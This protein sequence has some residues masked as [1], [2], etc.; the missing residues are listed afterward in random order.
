M[1]GI[2]YATGVPVPTS[3]AAGAGVSCDGMERK[4]V[5]LENPGTATYQLQISLKNPGGTVPGSGD[6]SWVNYGSALTAAG[7]VEVSAP[8]AWVRWNATAYTN[9]TPASQLAGIV[10]QAHG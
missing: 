1:A 4:T 7:V 2:A 6:N 9:G 5:T 8:C 10:S 3:V